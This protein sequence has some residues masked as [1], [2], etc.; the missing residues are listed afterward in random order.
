MQ[1]RSE[2]VVGAEVE[3][4]VTAVRES[5]S[6]GDLFSTPAYQRESA[7][8]KSIR[9]ERQR[10]GEMEMSS[11]DCALPRSRCQQRL[12]CSLNHLEPHSNVR[13][14]PFHF[15]RSSVHIHLRFW[16]PASG[17]AM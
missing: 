3:Q 13:F 6:A 11:W 12:R 5:E 16:C 4:Q 17:R 8:R 14:L 15:V 1:Q 9:A 2:G 10:S 7:R